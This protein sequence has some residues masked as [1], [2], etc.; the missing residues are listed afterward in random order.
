MLWRRPNVG[1]PGKNPVAEP[2][3]TAHK[4]FMVRKISAGLCELEVLWGRENVGGQ[5]F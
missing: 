5:I 2:K 1:H 3:R 4:S